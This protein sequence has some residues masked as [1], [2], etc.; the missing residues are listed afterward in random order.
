MFN[1]EL[2]ENIDMKRQDQGR[3]IT[4]VVPGLF[5]SLV[6]ALFFSYFALVQIP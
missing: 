4:P 3:E 1:G 5:D 6:I 2:T